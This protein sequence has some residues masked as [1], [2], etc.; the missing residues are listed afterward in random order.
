MKALRSGPLAGIRV[1]EL[2]GLVPPSY[3]GL[4]LADFG[5]DVIKIEKGAKASIGESGLMDTLARGKRSVA[6]DLKTQQGKAAFLRM[7]KQADV[8]IEG[9]RPGVVERLGV[10]PAD[11]H[12][13]NPGCIYAR[14]TGWGQTGPYKNMAGHDLNYIGI[15]GALS[16]LAPKDGEIP[17][18]PINLLGDFAGGGMTCALGIVMALVERSR[19]GKGQVVD[20]AMVDGAG[21]LSAWFYGVHSHF[22]P[23]WQML[24]QTLSGKPGH[25]PFYRCY[26]CKDGKFVTVGAIESKF[27]RILQEKLGLNPAS[28]PPQNDTSTW[29]ATSTKFA[30]IFETRTRDDWINNVF[31]GTDACVGPVL[32]MDE[33]KTFNQHVERPYMF[34]HAISKK[35][36]RQGWQPGPAPRLSRTPGAAGETLPQAG[37][38]TAEILKEFGFTD[39]E[40]AA[41]SPTPQSKL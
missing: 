22:P 19:S 12:A 36:S 34:Q 14:M 40:I 21:Y 24:R 1:L 8:I 9:N 2:A 28:E 32:D 39:A 29:E 5:A 26:K 4:I 27:Y 37:E 30:Q 23:L 6:L 25:A 18:P 33:V 7:A 10:G 16:Q 20:A 17:V 35:S 11:I 41:L 3:V 13:F 38:N 15:T 31:E